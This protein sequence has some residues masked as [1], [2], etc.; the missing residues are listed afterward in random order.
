MYIV[1]MCKKIVKLTFLQKFNISTFY[2]HLHIFHL[3]LLQFFSLLSA[4]SEYQCPANSQPSITHFP[5]STCILAVHA[6]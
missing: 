1:Y 5:L 4:L 3:K 2:I 6:K